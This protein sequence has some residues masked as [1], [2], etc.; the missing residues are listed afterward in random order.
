MS[1]ARSGEPCAAS[2]GCAARGEGYGVLG[3]Y[4]RARRSESQHEWKGE[5]YVKQEDVSRDD[6]EFAEIGVLGHVR[7]G[8][9]LA[10]LFGHLGQLFLPSVPSWTQQTYGAIEVVNL[11]LALK[12]D[13]VI[14][15]D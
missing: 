7:D 1:I 4:L 9:F 10:K 12:D 11:G 13:F 6:V 3:G 15:Q 2:R 5:T 8:A 14:S